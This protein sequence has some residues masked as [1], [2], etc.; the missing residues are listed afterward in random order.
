MPQEQRGAAAATAAAVE[1]E[2]QTS[3]SRANSPAAESDDPHAWTGEPR[4]IYHNVVERVDRLRRARWLAAS[5]AAATEGKTNS[6]VGPD[7][8]ELR[9]VRLILNPPGDILD[10]VNDEVRL[11]RGWAGRRVEGGEGR[12]GST[13]PMVTLCG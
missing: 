1:Q 9:Y 6:R 10:F 5:A 13:V 12:E 8:E 7:E 11:R 4:V 3:T 2:D